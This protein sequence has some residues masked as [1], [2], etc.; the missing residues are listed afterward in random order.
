VSIKKSSLE[1]IHEGILPIE[2]IQ[3][4]GNGVARKLAANFR[5]PPSPPFDKRGVGGLSEKFIPMPTWPF[6]FRLGRVRKDQ[7]RIKKLTGEIRQ[8]YDVFL[9]CRKGWGNDPDQN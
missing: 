4:L 2:R 1:I 8:A 7:K 6:W 5:N 3:S 9:R